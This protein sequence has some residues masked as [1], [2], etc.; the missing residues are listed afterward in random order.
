MWLER[1]FRNPWRMNILWYKIK[2]K[3]APSS[4]CFVCAEV[5]LKHICYCNEKLLKWIAMV[6]E[7]E[8]IKEMGSASYIPGKLKLLKR[9]FF[10]S[11]MAKATMGYKKKKQLNDRMSFKMH[12][13]YV[14]WTQLAWLLSMCMCIQSPFISEVGC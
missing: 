9:L 12:F 2:I 10:F 13:C 4:L 6:N 1:G 7:V 5:P 14:I 8:A 3:Q 11:S